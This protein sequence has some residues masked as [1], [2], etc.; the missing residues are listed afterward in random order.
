MQESILGIF[1]K[2]WSYYPKVR[3]SRYSVMLETKILVR[4][5]K[6]IF[7][8]KSVK[9]Y[10]KYPNKH[11]LKMMVNMCAKLSKTLLER[12]SEL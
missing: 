8:E 3:K 12:L 5:I 9:K 2:I 7:F 4:A 11:L 6:K 1:I 10:N